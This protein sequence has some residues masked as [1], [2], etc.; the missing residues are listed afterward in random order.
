[1]QWVVDMIDKVILNHTNDAML[2]SIKTEIE[3]KVMH[4]PLFVETETV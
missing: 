3:Q 2:N 1:M 4:K